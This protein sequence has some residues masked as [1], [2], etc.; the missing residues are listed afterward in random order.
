M[1]THSR[2]VAVLLLL[3]VSGSAAAEQNQPK[4][5][6]YASPKELFA[7]YKKAANAEDWRAIFSLSTSACIN[8]ELAE[9]VFYLDFAEDN[10][11]KR[12][13]SI[14]K[15]YG[16]DWDR[17]N[18]K[19][20]GSLSSEKLNSLTEKKGIA[21][22]EKTIEFIASSVKDKAG[23]YEALHVYVSKLS[24]VIRSEVHELRRLTQVGSSA[25]GLSI[26]TD[27]IT[28][29]VSVNGG[30]PSKPVDSTVQGAEQL[31][32]H[33]VDGK[34]YL[35]ARNET[36]GVDD[37]HR[38]IV[39]AEHKIDGVFD[40]WKDFKTGWKETGGVGSGTFGDGIDLKQFYYQNDGK[41]LY[42]F[43]KC[44]PS[45]EER[46]KKTGHQ[47]GNLAWLYVD[48]D[49]S[50]KTGVIRTDD[51]AILG[52]DIRMWV[53]ILVGVQ[54]K[55]VDGKLES[56]RFCG[57][58]LSILGWDQQKKA[59]S[60]WKGSSSS[61]DKHRYIAHGKDGVEIAILLSDLGKSKGDKFDF[62]CV[63]AAHSEPRFTNR[64]SITVD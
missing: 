19:L 17:L 21:V 57:V 54:S 26:S 32:F 63:E 14:L 23:L 16:L 18:A 46:D 34:W 50:A 62:I 60:I 51:S 48:S 53:P 40:D 13:K 22:A 37:L 36:K 12:M 8:V 25:S 10:E 31:F 1:L 4:S 49:S 42:L 52:A 27:R 41:W 5:T 29:T 43:F 24:P 7:A 30:P 15:K 38:G 11:S 56:K 58:T 39:P 20:N 45:I 9:S 33:R 47:S 61:R 64:I 3:V 28:E 59:F 6:G 44:E 35:A 55:R 2:I